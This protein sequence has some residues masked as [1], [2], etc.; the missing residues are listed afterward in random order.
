MSS[1]KDFN[2][3]FNQKI[4]YPYFSRLYWNF[5]IVDRYKEDTILTFPIGDGSKTKTITY[6]KGMPRLMRSRLPNGEFIRFLAEK[7]QLRVI[8]SL[9]DDYDTDM[10]VWCTKYN[11]IHN[12]ELDYVSATSV[13][14]DKKDL[15]KYISIINNR[16]NFPMLIRCRAGADRTG[17]ACAIYR[18]EKQGWS[19]WKAWL[20]M[21]TYFHLPF[22]FPWPTKFIL[23]YK[24]G[25]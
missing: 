25:S 23:S 14:K 21:L 11:I 18:I 5:G 12:T 1:F 2:I 19:N 20:E 4:W 9:E 3:W 17:A 15:Y 16:M 22:I 13:F 24:K 10:N 6:K 8:L 7:Y